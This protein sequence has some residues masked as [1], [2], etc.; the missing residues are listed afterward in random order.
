MHS[1][2]KSARFAR[3]ACMASAF[4]DK[5][6]AVNLLPGALVPGVAQPLEPL[7]R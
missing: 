6:V 3:N 5:I 7:D 2:S 1:T 4:G